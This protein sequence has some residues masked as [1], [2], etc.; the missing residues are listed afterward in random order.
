MADLSSRTTTPR[1][2]AQRVGLAQVPGPLAKAPI[3]DGRLQ[4]LL[5][6]FAV[7]LPGIFLYYPDRRLVLPKLRALIDHVKSRSN[8]AGKTRSYADGRRT[9]LR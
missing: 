1:S 7:T 2:S 5:T 6:P 4:A 9:R 8:I 3:S